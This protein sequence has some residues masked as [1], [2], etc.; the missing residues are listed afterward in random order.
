[1]RYVDIEKEPMKITEFL[2]VYDKII[3]QVI[4]TEDLLIEPI[5]GKINENSDIITA[6]SDLQ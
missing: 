4:H 5:Q 2:L 3:S 6:V 1:M